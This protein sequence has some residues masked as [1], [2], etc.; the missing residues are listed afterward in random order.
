MTITGLTVGCAISYGVLTNVNPTPTTQTLSESLVTAAGVTIA[1]PATGIAITA[2]GADRVISGSGSWSGS[3]G[4]APVSLAHSTNTYEMVPAHS[5]ATG[6]INP[7]FTY[8]W[9]W[10]KAISAA[11]GP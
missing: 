4:D 10:A 7:T 8:G 11:W 2:V 1:V 9:M 5:T 6:T 3:T